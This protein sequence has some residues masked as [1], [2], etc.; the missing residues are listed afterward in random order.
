M[1]KGGEN[2]TER[3]QTPPLLVRCQAL[4]DEVGRV[5][6]VSRERRRRFKIRRRTESVIKSADAASNLDAKPEF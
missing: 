3:H 4:R 6:E 1:A 2:G 5:I